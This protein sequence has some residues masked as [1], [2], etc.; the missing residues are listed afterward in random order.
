[1]KKALFLGLC[2]F[3]LAST[4]TAADAR[5]RFGGVHHFGGGYQHFGVYRHFGGYGGY[6]GWGGG[7]VVPGQTFYYCQPWQGVLTYDAYG[8]P[9]CVR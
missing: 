6:G 4:A 3:A 5:G 9:V 7:Y 8:N 1:M 2:A